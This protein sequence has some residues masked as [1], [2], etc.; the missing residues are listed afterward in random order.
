MMELLMPLGLLGLLGIAILILIYILKPNYQQKVV[1][2]TYVWKLSLRYRRKQI[3]I[4]RLLSFLILLC[5]ILIV[6]ACAFILAQPFIPSDQLNYGNERIIVIDASADMLA[7]H[8]DETRFERAVD[9]AYAMAE[10]TFLLDDGVVSVILADNSP[11]FVVQRADASRRA[12]VFD[13]IDGLRGSDDGEGMRCSY[14]QADVDAAMDLAEQILQVNSSASVF[15]ITA[16]SYAD[17]GEVE[18]VD[19][20]VE[21]EWNVGILDASVALDQNYYSVTAQVAAYGRSSSVVVRCEIV[22]ANSADAQLVQLESPTLLCA[23]GTPRTVEFRTRPI[24]DEDVVENGVSEEGDTLVIWSDVNVESYTRVRLTIESDDGIDDY[25]YDNAVELYGGRR[26]TLNIQYASPSTLMNSFFSN[27]FRA[28]RET[29][30][31][32]WDINYTEVRVSS[33]TA[34]AT[35]GYDLYIFEHSMPEILPT[36]GVVILVNPDSAPSGAGFDIESDSVIAT[37]GAFT[38]TAGTPH[39]ITDGVRPERIPVTQYK[40]ITEYEGYESLLYVDGDPVLLAKNDADSKVMVMAFS[41]NDSIVTLLTDFGRIIYQ[42]FN[43][44]VPSA[45][46]GE[47]GLPDSLFEI[48]DQVTLNARGPELSVTLP[49]SSDALIY[50][51]FPSTITLEVPGTYGYEQT[52]ISQVTSSGNFYVKVAASESDLTR[53]ESALPELEIPDTGEEG[54]GLDLLLYFAIA[55]FALLFIEWLLQV[56]E[57]Y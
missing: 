16:T 30:R 56:K 7:S 18:V 42:M 10:D 12:A 57:N 14:A 4:N 41:V 55:L 38:L 20:S 2:S 21:G 35:E 34:A 54:E 45:V 36:D 11:E 43:Y 23:E 1:S 27:A 13:A 37:D 50:D 29:F 46:T 9:E 24:R 22:G 3:P 25:S 39:A 44:Y 47:D 17:P 5:Q 48:G 49:S 28:L 33:S 52:L 26:E 51:T 40:R 31:L 15:Y 8:N 53:E 19:V 6:T 32:Y